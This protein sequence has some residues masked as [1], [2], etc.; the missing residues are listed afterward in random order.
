MVFALA[1]L[2]SMKNLDIV[3]TFTCPLRYKIKQY[4]RL[5]MKHPKINSPL[6]H[7]TPWATPS[8]Q[9]LKIKMRINS[10]PTLTKY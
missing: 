1:I 3:R 6:I 4:N 9:G 5:V 8:K 7:S 10:L 2:G